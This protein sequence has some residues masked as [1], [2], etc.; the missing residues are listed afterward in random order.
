MWKT[1]TTQSHRSVGFGCSSF[2]QCN[3]VVNFGDE[4]PGAASSD[5]LC[6]LCKSRF[7]EV[8]KV[9]SCV[10]VPLLWVPALVC[11]ALFPRHAT[12]KRQRGCVSPEKACRAYTS[13]VMVVG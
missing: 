4:G 8:V 6:S 11:A 12:V 2:I 3:S 9:A 13:T 1:F 7:C 5:E 10:R